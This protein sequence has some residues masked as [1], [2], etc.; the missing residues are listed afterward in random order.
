M[1]VK[2]NHCVDCGLPCLGRSC[3]N[4]E[5]VVIYCD[6]CGEYADYCLDNQDFCEECAKA[7]VNEIWDDLPMREKAK[8][9]DVTYES[10]N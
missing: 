9:L 6:N 1:K 10:Y 4:R 3:P 5:V 7:Y 8:I 2:E